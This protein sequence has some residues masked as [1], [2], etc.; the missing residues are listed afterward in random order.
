MTKEEQRPPAAA[1]GEGSRKVRTTTEIAIRVVTGSTRVSSQLDGVG[2]PLLEPRVKTLES[3]GEDALDI[4]FAGRP[5]R[6][7][8]I[9]VHARNPDEI[10]E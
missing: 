8:E 1:P 9:R 2:L 10:L 5:L 4:T 3:T 7:G 6:T